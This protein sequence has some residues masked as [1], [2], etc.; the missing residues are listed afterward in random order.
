MKFE[1][2]LNGTDKNPFHRFGLSQN[3]FPQ[4]AKY[5]VAPHLLHLQKLGGDPIP[6]EDYIRRHLEGWSPEFIE[7]CC[8][9]FRKGELVKF[10]VTFPD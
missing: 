8:Q 3:P 1:V 10:I 5:E 6:D 7:G 2:V 4:V 9:R